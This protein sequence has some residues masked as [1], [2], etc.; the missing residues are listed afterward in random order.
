VAEGESRAP[1]R[2][3]AS[4]PS[5]LHARDHC[6][7]PPTTAAGSRSAAREG[8]RGH[9]ASA[10]ATSS[11]ALELNPAGAGYQGELGT[12]ET[13]ANRFEHA[14]AAFDKALAA[15]PADY[16]ALTGLGLLRL[17]RGDAAGA[18]DAFLRAGVLEP[19]YARRATFTAVAYYQLGRHADAIATFRE[20]AALDEKDPL[21]Y[22]FL[23]QVYTDLFRA[24]DAV[25][26]SRE[27]LK[28]LPYLKSLNQVA[29]NQ[30][31]TANF[32][33]SLAFFGLEA[34]ALEV[35]QQSYSPYLA[36]S[37]LFL[38]DRYP[39]QYNKNSELLQGFLTDPTAFG[40]SNRFSTL[41]PRTGSYGT[42]GA[43]YG[44]EPRLSRRQPVSA[45]ERPRRLLGRS[46]YFLDAESGTGHVL[47]PT[48][49]AP[50]ATARVK[51]DT[52][53]E[54]YAA[55][56]RRRHH[57]KPRRLSVRH[58]RA[59]QR[60]AARRGG[61]SHRRTRT[62]PTWACATASRPPR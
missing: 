33:Y 53:V 55:G 31:G 43:S 24:G 20:A 17:K 38:A 30:Q 11:K 57:R 40:G 27:A 2:R 48:P 52:R 54:L 61:P 21:P 10:R 3:R 8:T 42:L 44:A 28:R 9:D 58:A 47:R 39:G 7:L 41:T 32:G 13:F 19:R 49:P 37:H 22:L 1:R 18:L 60:R 6:A 51:G 35:A 29:N 46:A 62:A 4:P 12:L 5:R 50:R 56:A 36:A 34:W 59:Q 26:A 14:Q 15:N 23:T 45:P 16:V 25:E